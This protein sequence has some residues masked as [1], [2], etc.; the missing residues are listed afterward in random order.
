MVIDF[1]GPALAGLD[2][3]SGVTPVVSARNGEILDPVG[4]Y[5]VV[6]TDRWRLI[7]DFRQTGA[8][9]ASLRAYLEKDGQALSETW[10]SDAWVDIRG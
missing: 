5:K 4:A 8:A 3:D 2:N 9:P 10:V 1:Q 6:G 7:F